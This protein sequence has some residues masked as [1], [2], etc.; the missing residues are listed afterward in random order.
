MEVED[1][2]GR[3]RRDAIRD[4]VME[5]VVVDEEGCFI[6]QGPTSGSGRGGGYP[7]MCLDGGTMA[8]HRVMWILE[9]GP[10]PPRKQLDHTCR[11]RRCVNPRCTEMVTH[12][13][14]Q[15]RRA[16]AARTPCPPS[17]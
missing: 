12:L 10:I 2:T 13:T 16:A 9:N 8:V 17:A 1:L 6:W 14:N 4:R 15:R 3:S 7:R 5:R 11:K